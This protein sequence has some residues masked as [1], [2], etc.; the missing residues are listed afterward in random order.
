MCEWFV[1]DKH[2]SSM[3]IKQYS[4]PVPWSVSD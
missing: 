4:H 3:A 2:G 1:S